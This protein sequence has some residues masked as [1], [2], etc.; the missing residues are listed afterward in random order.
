MYHNPQISNIYRPVFLSRELYADQRKFS[1]LMKEYREKIIL[2]LYSAQKKELVKIRNPRKRLTEAEIESMYAE[3]ANDRN[4]DLEG[5]WIYYPWSNRLLHI[6]DKDEFIELRT[7]RNHYKIAP[8]EQTELSKRKIGIIGLS[9]GHAVAITMATERVCGTLKLA[10]FDTLELSNLNRIKTGIHNIGVNKCIITAREIAEIDPFLEIECYPE[11]ITHQNITG[12][13]TDNGKLDILVD[14]C[15]DLEIKIYCRE[16]AKSL[17]I[18]VV[19]ETSDRGMLDVE[20][21]DLHADRSILHGLLDG[22]PGEKLRNIQPADRVPLVM[23]IIDAM[24]SSHRGRASLLEVG[25][26]ISTWPQLASAVTLG[27]GVVT[28]VCR[29][30]LLNHFTDSG[31]YYVDLE[32]I[33]ANKHPVTAAAVYSNPNQKFDLNIAIEAV[34]NL[35]V[36]LQPVTPDEHE[37]RQIIGASTDTHSLGNDYEWKWLYRNGRLHLFHDAYRSFTFANY[38]NM[39]A[40]LALG[41]AYESV[42]SECR[43]LG[44]QV[45]T[46]FSPSSHYP[47]LLATIHFTAKAVI[48]SEIWAVTAKTDHAETAIANPDENTQPE[49]QE[50]LALQLAA[51]RI[52][53]AGLQLITDKDNINRLGRI[54]GECN[55]L[56]MLNDNGHYDFF[57]RNMD[58]FADKK[59]ASNRNSVISF[60]N[61][62]AQ[63]A[64]LSIIRDKKVANAIK[65]IGGGNM[66]V[67]SVQQ[68]VAAASCLA[69]LQLPK[70]G[71]Q[72]YFS[73]GIA[74]QRLQLYAAELGLT[75]EP[76]LSPLFLFARMKSGDG[77]NDMEKNKLQELQNQFQSIIETD[78]DSTEVLILKVTKEEKPLLK[79][80][81][82]PLDEIL[83]MVNNTI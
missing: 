9:V 35:S 20:R 67:E 22:I 47:E 79:T 75:L 18:P 17:H 6:L 60:G 12:F 41:A 43:K 7:T 33:V 72:N 45:E 68:A 61:N 37:I 46:H 49:D 57:E 19:M 56:M 55:L 15:D 64:A 78:E 31:R 80:S 70:T 32:E 30:I 65:I 27:G 13:M 69:V 74:A 44:Y 58:W 16:V 73:G 36:S 25:Q 11:G 52:G 40:H 23:K 26:S 77:L 81:P 1:F 63:L 28:D 62:P 24:K 66:L 82:L 38:N 14:E 5:C 42:I 21:F 53:G 71:E 59:A 50:Y 34:D 39:A 83:F 8:H 2:D 51:E 10:D 48:P 4:T 29:R 76:L 3:W 54:I